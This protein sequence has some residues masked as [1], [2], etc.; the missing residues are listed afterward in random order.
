[1]EANTNN[2]KR[3]HAN[4]FVYMSLCKA[5]YESMQAHPQLNLNCIDYKQ[6]TLFIWKSM[7][8]ASVCKNF[9]DYKRK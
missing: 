2:Y 7:Q 1:M 5:I 4:N 6:I 8:S 3:K 9:I